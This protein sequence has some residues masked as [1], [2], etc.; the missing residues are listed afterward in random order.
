MMNL[1]EMGDGRRRLESGTVWEP[2]M[3]YSRA[4]QAGP[5]ICVSGCV[6][7]LPD[8]RYPATLRDQAARC[9]DRIRDAL[10]AF[11]ADLS[12]VIRLRIYTTCITEWEEI[13]A[14]CGPALAAV[15]PANSLVEVSRLI[16]P[17]ALIEIEA[18]AWLDPRPGTVR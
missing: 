17:Q 9:L 6:G 10:A 18:D 1:V 5:L 8:G 16:D 12:H 4:V 11:G 14:I 13:A 7:I 15:R 3:G 2:K